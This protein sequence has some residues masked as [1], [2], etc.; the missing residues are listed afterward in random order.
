MPVG[1]KAFLLEKLS[2]LKIAKKVGGPGGGGGGGTS[3]IFQWWRGTKTYAQGF[4]TTSI[5]WEEG[6]NE[7]KLALQTHS[8]LS[9]DEWH[10]GSI[11]RPFVFPPNE[12]VGWTKMA[13]SGLHQAWWCQWPRKS[14][15]VTR[16]RQR[17]EKQANTFPFLLRTV[18]S[19]E[20]L[21]L[22]TPVFWPY[23]GKPLLQ[24]I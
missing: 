9:W 20:R 21:K 1:T 4:F 19:R 14:S 11:L 6:R 15:G 12:M 16:Q 18:S 5:F 7:E 8:F 2:V 13:T 23:S 24:E 10:R 22:A 17:E 3:L